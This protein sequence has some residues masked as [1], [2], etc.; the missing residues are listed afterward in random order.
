M[1]SSSMEFIMKYPTVECS[2]V[3]DVYGESANDKMKYAYL[4]D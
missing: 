3:Y 4:E 1:M 2:S